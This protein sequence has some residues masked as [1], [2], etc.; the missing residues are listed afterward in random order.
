MANVKVVMNSAGAI[1]VLN[2]G[3]IQN[4]CLEAAQKIA[5]SASSQS[6]ASYIADVQSGKTRAHARAKTAD[7]HAANIEYNYNYLLKSMKRS[8]K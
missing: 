5:S 4:S 2:S 6:G 1:D 8:K 3:A 7:Q